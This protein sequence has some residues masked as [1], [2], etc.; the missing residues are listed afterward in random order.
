MFKFFLRVFNTLF[1]QI[2]FIQFVSSQV[3]TV[4]SLDSGLLNWY[5]QDLELDRVP[6]ISTERVYKEILPNKASKKTVIVAIIDSGVDI[7]HKD[8][9]G[10]IWINEAEIAGN[11]I[12][13]DNNG[14][15]D[16]V[17][18]WNFI[19][20]DKG[21][22]IQLENFEYTRIYKKYSSK[23]DSISSNSEISKEEEKEYVVYRK[24]KELYEKNLMK[25]K[26]E[27]EGISMFEEIFLAAKEIIKS[28]TGINPV[29]LKDLK[30]IKTKDKKTSKAISFLIDKYKMG[31]T[32][33]KIS[34]YKNHTEECLDKHLN[35]E[36]NPREIVGDNPLDISDI[37]Y[38]NNDVKG[39]RS[40]HG[41]SVAGVIAANRNNGIGING[42]AENVK[43][44]VLRT[45]PQGDEYDKDVALAIKYAA[46]NGANII[47]MSF[48]KEMS[49]N[50]EFVDE[51][52]KYAASKNILMI[53]SSGNSALDVDKI[54]MYPTDILNDGMVV[55]SWISVGASTKYKTSSIAAEFS[56]YGKTNVDIFA[57][58]KDIISLEPENLYSMSDGTS[59]SSP[60]VTGVAALVWSYYPELSAIQL[61]EVLLN[62][63]K[64]NK[65]GKVL[66]PDLESEKR[67]KG[68]FSQLSVSGG[69]LNAYEAMKMAEKMVN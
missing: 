59:L 46:D 4:D 33:E 22:N 40:D 51:A 44:M 21:E 57:P 56:N 48:G 35:L 18:G 42:V 1:F 60:I 2:I 24:S 45:V 52:I 38:G 66:I 69:V 41:T 49:P 30:S 16:D 54:E 26:K 28:E 14:Y 55:E 8:L 7:Y 50:K 19:G 5:N 39:P 68:K 3:S 53:N 65:K 9:E 58:G 25:Y 27:Q 15:A 67:P 17:H 32:E 23:F 37:K 47:N 11:E 29:S 63:S 12:D 62:S 6:G 13:D 34:E 61:K 36:F 10:K 20:N 43:L 64:K 31:L